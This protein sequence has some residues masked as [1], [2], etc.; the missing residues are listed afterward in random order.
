MSTPTERDQLEFLGNL[1]R[2][3][4]EG[5]FVATYKYALLLSL[6]DLAIE[7]GDDSG[8]PLIICTSH[9]AEK[10]V[11]YYW[12]QTAP[13][14]VKLAQRRP[15][16][17]PILRQN[18]G[19][20]AAI[21]NYISSYRQ[22]YP[23]LADLRRDARAWNQL[24]RQV[25]QVVRVMPLWKLQT[26]G[27]QSLDFLYANSRSGR[28]IELK[29]GIAFCLRRF[30]LLINDLVRGAWLRYIRENNQQILATAADLNEFLFGSERSS[31]TAIQSVLRDSQCGR[32]FYCELSLSGV[33]H[34][35]HFIPWSRYRVDLG[36]N[37][38]LA[39]C[40]CNMKK[41][42]KL[43]AVEHLRRWVARNR[44]Q[45]V[46]LA[47]GFDR[48]KIVHDRIASE[49]VAGWAYSQ[50]AAVHGLAWIKENQLVPVTPSWLNIFRGS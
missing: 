37:F 25:D 27:R 49:R 20:Q 18:T 7:L 26:V 31:L 2:L 8:R 29:A 4:S 11:Q 28:T 43:A 35:D 5:Q 3:L 45:N 42:D 30:Y 32:C 38:V 40:S 41:G 48:R 10:F 24:T 23:T 33:T 9:I 16:E 14:P 50:A 19:R 46:E 6:A 13:Y 44:E 47:E 36:H 21:I 12:Q 34:V 15:A 1:Q 39:H 17:D 22:Q